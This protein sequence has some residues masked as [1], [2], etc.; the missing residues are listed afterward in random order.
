M[1]TL[2]LFITIIIFTNSAYKK[3][4]EAAHNKH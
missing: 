4:F 1:Y 2:E 3:L